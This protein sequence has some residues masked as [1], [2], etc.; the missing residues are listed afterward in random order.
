MIG[1]VGLVQTLAEQGFYLSEED[2]LAVVVGLD[3]NL[4]YEKLK[5]ATLL[6]RSGVPFIGT[7]PDRT[8][9]TPQGLIPGAGAV[10]A[11]VEAATDVKPVYAG[12][13][14]TYLYQLALDRLAVPPQEALV[15]GDRLDT[16]I[17]GGQSLGC[18]TGLVL[19]GV[20]TETEALNWKPA[21]DYIAS[22]LFSLLNLI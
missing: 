21:L 11:A 8:F 14:E 10:I 13:P 7:N 5:K 2:V 22:D 20:S 17:T 6:I 1:E 18:K 9:P 4:T 3:R 16:D 12:K 19:T 15:I